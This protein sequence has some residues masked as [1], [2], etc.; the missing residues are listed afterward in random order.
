MPF[1]QVK[2]ATI[3][4]GVFA[5]SMEISSICELRGR[6]RRQGLQATGNRYLSRDQLRFTMMPPL[7]SIQQLSISFSTPGGLLPGVENVC[8]D[9]R[10][11][12]I[13]ALVGESGSGKSITALSILQLLPIPPARVTSG[14][15]YLTGRDGRTIDLLRQTPEQ[16]QKIR[17]G[18]IAMIFQEPMT[19]L[20]PVFT[21]GD[22]VMEAIR[23]HRKLGSQDVR[24]MAIALFEKVKLPDPERMLSRYPHQLSGGQKQRV[25]I[26]MAMSGGPSLLICD[27]PTTALD[28]TVQK[29]I[30]E[31][32]RG[33]QREEDLGVI[34]ITHDLGVV[35]E[36]ADRALVLYKGKIVEEGPVKELF[37]RPK[38]PYTKGLLNC[39]PALH[40]K[41]E[42]LPVV[43]DFMGE[44][45]GAASVVRG[46]EASVGGGMRSV[47]GGTG[48]V[49]MIIDDLSVW[50]PLRKNWL[51]KPVQY[52]KAVD[53][54]S[55]EVYRGETLGLVGES[56]CGKTT[57]GRAMLRLVEPTAGR[58]MFEG[59]ELTALS[60]GEVK[61]RRSYIQ[62]IFQDPYSS[63][64]PRLS[65]GRAISEAMEVHGIGATDRER[66]ARVVEL[67][68]KVSLRA[69]HFDRYPHEFSGGQRQRIV[70]ARALSLHP[71][72]LVCDES[73][74]ALDVSVQAQ[75]LNLLN[76]LKKEFGF[77]VVFISHDLSVIRYI[78]DRILVMNKGRIEEIGEAE[79]VYSHPKTDYTQKLIDAIPAVGRMWN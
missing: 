52:T 57:L 14:E 41:G 16:L 75:V 56:G 63:L 17:G 7:L 73:V 20:N 29:T 8:L 78:S 40:R 10:R 50:Y 51:G 43:S 70:I 2:K 54:V 23:T 47:S 45:G 74:S 62:L 59:A 65:I 11:G 49:T 44:A 19:S 21:C 15:I 64:N 66:K 4:T 38:H 48:E 35:A 24:R 60:A 27:E 77:T 34:F 28:V 58:V 12:E 61:K 22:Q 31:L 25:M 79:A 13:V 55:F 33:L 1:C 69:D 32:I 5:L 71:S 6:M 37:S 68:E 9:V 39:R 46:G 76:D 72:F 67:L 36:I 26:A 18:E 30:L 53:G 3:S 42:R